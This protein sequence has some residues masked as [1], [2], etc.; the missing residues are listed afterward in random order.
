MTARSLLSL[1]RGKGVELRTS[2]AD[3]LVIDAPKGIITPELRQDL[4]VNKAELL[5]IL[6]AEQLAAQPGAATANP[7]ERAFGSDRVSTPAQS[8]E[9]ATIMT[10]DEIALLEAELMRLRK[11]EE[12][13][14]A[15]VEATRMAAENAL[16]VAQEL[17]RQ[18][19]QKA[20]RCR[21]EKEKHRIEAEARE[22]VAEENHRRIAEQEIA[23]AEEE[24]RRMRAMEE[25]RRADVDA[26]LRAAAEAHRLEFE[27]LHKTEDE[28]ARRRSE[29][30]RRYMDLM[31]QSKAQEDEL[32]RD[33]EMRMRA[34]EKQ[35][36]RT[37]AQEEARQGAADEGR[38]VGEETA[39]QRVEEAARQRAE[40][41]AYRRAE[42]EARDADR[43]NAEL[44]AR[45][46]AE[47]EV[48]V[49]EEIKRREVEVVRLRAEEER[50]RQEEHPPMIDQPVGSAEGVTGGAEWFDVVMMKS[51]SAQTAGPSTALVPEE[52]Q[53]TSDR[54][55]ENF[56]AITPDDAG[57]QFQ[58]VSVPES[59]AV[60]G[61]SNPAT[62]LD[63]LK[64]KKSGERAAAV[65]DLARSGGEDA[66]RQINTAFDDQAVEVRSAAARALFE[67]QKDHAAAFTRAFREAPAERRRRIGTAIASSGLASEAIRNLT[68]ES[69]D[70][71]YDAFSLLFLMSKAG[72]I[73]SL[74]R[75]IEEDPNIEV[76]LAVVKLLA[77]SHQA[78]T[79]PAFRRMAARESLPP[80]V[81]SA[82]IEA[83]SQ[84]AGQPADA[85][86]ML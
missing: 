37:R 39:R 81:R 25:S 60:E 71:S 28:Q 5:Q 68:G 44:E 78:D 6:Q 11:E 70:Q 61:S 23:R 20:V 40:A 36:L 1:L 16:R 19:E 38:R 86:S 53:G 49:R 24:V 45:I 83:I 50:F 57:A 80:E 34:V 48:R 47:V 76:R 41:E 10:T 74:V 67:F 13:R 22:R 52:D 62:T 15:E 58:P 72:E 29:E 77:L 64:S 30:E 8:S 33:A 3:R 26:K 17:W 69:R 84:I 59:A 31:A 9:P 32:R 75:A 18:E 85:P 51:D 4:A 35:I 65:L 82:V 79:L 73:R 27:T 12:A 42:E 14:R 56:G 21:A 7:T 63:Q 2:G 46:R 54:P 55:N 66:F 43:Q